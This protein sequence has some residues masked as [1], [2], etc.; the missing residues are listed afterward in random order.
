MRF[1]MTISK[2]KTIATAMVIGRNIRKIRYVEVHLQKAVIESVH[3]FVGKDPSH[4]WSRAGQIG[5]LPISPPTRVV[6]VLVRTCCRD[7]SHHLTVHCNA[8]DSVAV[9]G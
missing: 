9:I 5:H 4:G 2:G 1:P 7:S 8:A 6:A 3:T